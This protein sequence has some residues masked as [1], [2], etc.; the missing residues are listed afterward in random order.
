MNG[1]LERWMDGSMDG[2]MGKWAAGEVGEQPG[3]E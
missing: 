2:W 1:C 3:D